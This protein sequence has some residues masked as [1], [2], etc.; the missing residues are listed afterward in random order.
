M[1]NY[2]LIILY[3]VREWNTDSSRI[4]RT[5]GPYEDKDVADQ[6]NK[7]LGYAG[8]MIKEKWIVDENRKGY[9]LVNPV[10][11]P[12]FIIPKLRLS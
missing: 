2:K 12:E 4:I 5:L 3:Y 11:C 10:W 6:V 1:D 7:D 8:N 9:K